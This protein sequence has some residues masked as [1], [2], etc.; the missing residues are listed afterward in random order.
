MLKQTMLLASLLLASPAYSQN[1]FLDYAKYRRDL[2]L[3]KGLRIAE[4]W[5]TEE[6]VREDRINF[7]IAYMYQ[8]SKYVHQEIDPKLLGEVEHDDALS[9][10]QALI[11]VDHSGGN[12][13]AAVVL[14][15]YQPHGCRTPFYK[16]TGD[17]FEPLACEDQGI[18]TSY[19]EYTKD[20]YIVLLSFCKDDVETSKRE[21]LN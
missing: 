20:Y 17:V 5:S 19:T 16:Q 9:M 1:T 8:G 18:T 10:A 14:D 6:W 21:L 3:E 11:S 15:W 7:P 2:I 12:C 13:Q 4:T